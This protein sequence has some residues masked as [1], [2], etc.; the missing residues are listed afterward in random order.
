MYVG[1]W[2]N[3]CGRE[4][5]SGKGNCGSFI[6]LVPGKTFL[7]RLITRIL[8]ENMDLW[9]PGRTHPILIVCYTN[10]AL[11][12]FLEGVLQDLGTDGR[13]VSDFPSIIRLGS[14]SSSEMLQ[15]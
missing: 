15:R 7:G 4:E 1:R 13:E 6:I 9:N 11:D 8:L 5:W 14:R 10:H 12:Q 3:A 2:V